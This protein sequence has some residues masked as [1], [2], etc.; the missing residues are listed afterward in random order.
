M[1]AGADRGLPPI[2]DKGRGADPP[3]AL[4]FHFCITMQSIAS[5]CSHKAAPAIAG[6][7]RANALLQRRPRPSAPRV[8]FVTRAVVASE[9]PMGTEEFTAWATAPARVAKRSDLHTIM[10]R[11]KRLHKRH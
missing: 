2:A 5:R 3:T 6:R 7:G 11:H 4:L 9:K 8:S 10:V 1:C